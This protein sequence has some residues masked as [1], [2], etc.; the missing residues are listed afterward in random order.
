MGNAAIPSYNT[1]ARHPLVADGP[2]HS[3]HGLGMVWRKLLRLY[4]LLYDMSLNCHLRVL[5]GNLVYVMVLLRM[6]TVVNV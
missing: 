5:L 4:S 2:C 3:G 6:L 1:C